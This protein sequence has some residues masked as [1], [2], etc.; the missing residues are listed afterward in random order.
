MHQHNLSSTLPVVHPR[1]IPHCPTARPGQGELPFADRRSSG[2]LS[3]PN[4]RTAI[5]GSRHDLGCRGRNTV[6][7]Q[8]NAPAQYKHI[9]SSASLLQLRCSTANNRPTLARSQIYKFGYRSAPMYSVFA[10][11]ILSLHG[12]RS[13]LRSAARPS[14]PGG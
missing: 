8:L 4:P 14:R 5:F 11:N 9:Q 3:V 1:H 10:W 12:S 7:C 6:K 13:F 2:A